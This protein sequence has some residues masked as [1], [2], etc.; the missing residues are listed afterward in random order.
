MLASKG[1]YNKS[2]KR[3]KV[4]RA[5]TPT[6]HLAPSRLEKIHRA[7]FLVADVVWRQRV[8]GEFVFIYEEQGIDSSGTQIVH[9]RLGPIVSCSIVPKAKCTLSSVPF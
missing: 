3:L 5:N 4:K 1:N 8:D 9:P 7:Q 6:V 2:W